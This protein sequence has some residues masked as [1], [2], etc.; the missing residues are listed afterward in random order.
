[1]RHSSDSNEMA[2]KI[3]GELYQLNDGME[4][5]AYWT[6]CCSRSHSRARRGIS[7]PKRCIDIPVSYNYGFCGGETLLCV[8]VRIKM[9]TA[10]IIRL[11]PQDLDDNTLEDSTEYKE[12]QFQVD[13]QASISHQRLFLKADCRDVVKEKGAMKHES[14]SNQQRRGDMIKA[15][16]NLCESP[17]AQ[18]D[19]G[20]SQSQ[21]RRKPVKRRK[22]AEELEGEQLGGQ[23]TPRGI[24][25]KRARGPDD[26]GGLACPFYKMDPWKFDRCLAYKLSKMSYVKQH[27]LRHHDAPYCNCTICQHPLG[28]KVEQDSHT[29]SQDCQKTQCTLYVM[30]A[31]Q[32]RDIQRAAGRKITT[33]G[34]W[35]QVW[36]ILFPG[37][38]RPDSPFVKGHYFAEVLSSFQAF[39]HN[40]RPHIIEETFHQ[41]MKSSRTYHEVFDA[42]LNKIEHH[43]LTQSS[44]LDSSFHFGSGIETEAADRPV[45]RRSPSVNSLRSDNK[46]PP[47]LSSIIHDHDPISIPG[48]SVIMDDKQEALA[49]KNSSGMLPCSPKPQETLPSRS[50]ADTIESYG[51]SIGSPCASQFNQMYWP[52]SYQETS[53]INPEPQDMINYDDNTIDICQMGAIFEF[54]YSPSSPTA[55]YH[56]DIGAEIPDWA[57]G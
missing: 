31:E 22:D 55:T 33:E 19:P 57:E 46:E 4:P 28:N 30:T 38:K 47:S 29:G 44:R 39:Y 6:I 36:S 37:A 34:K 27:L 48:P 3:R 25:T 5:M 2:T 8:V 52:T 35:Y 1:M 21:S 51:L 24:S 16:M 32:K 9:C 23:T 17:A 11:S 50:G 54:T 53:L 41:V 10:V 15:A 45:V 56:V 14:T 42:L 7:V 18:K 12:K 20:I 40:S 49:L 13:A 43:A 26:T